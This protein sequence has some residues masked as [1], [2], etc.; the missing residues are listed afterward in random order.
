M[1]VSGQGRESRFPVCA[2]SAENWVTV[3]HP[4]PLHK[5]SCRIIK[6][7]KWRNKRGEPISVNGTQPYAAAFHE[8]WIFAS[9]KRYAVIFGN[10]R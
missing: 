1:L 8:N 6:S 3:V 5:P 7:A 9:L 4:N 2:V 10:Y